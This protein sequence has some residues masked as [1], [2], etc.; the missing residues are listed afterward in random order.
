M[1]DR[2]CSMPFN[3]SDNFH[4]VKHIARLQVFSYVPCVHSVSLFSYT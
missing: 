1:R 3:L 4:V 2:I